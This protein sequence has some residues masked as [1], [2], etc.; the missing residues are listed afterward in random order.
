M[1]II[2]KHTICL[3]TALAVMITSLSSIQAEAENNVPVVEEERV[4]EGYIKVTDFYT[5]EKKEYDAILLDDEIIYMT[6]DMLASM[7]GYRLEG[8]A[9]G[10]IRLQLPGR[11]SDFA[12]FIGESGVVKVNGESASVDMVDYQK[13]FYY[14]AN[15]ML[16]LLGGQFFQ[17]PEPPQPEDDYEN[18]YLLYMSERYNTLDF[19]GQVKDRM[20]SFQVSQSELLK[21]GRGTYGQATASTLAVVFGNMDLRILVPYF[22]EKWIVTDQYEEALQTLTVD[23]SGF[24]TSE[25]LAAISGMVQDSFFPE[26]MFHLH[27]ME[28]ILDLPD[29][30]S[31]TVKGGQDL[32]AI[33]RDQKLGLKL[34]GMAKD[35]SAFLKDEDL[36]AWSGIL[37][38][39]NTAVD[40]VSVFV[41]AYKT[42][43][44]GTSWSEDNIEQL[45]VLQNVN[46]PENGDISNYIKRAADKLIFEINWPT[47]AA[48]LQEAEG[49]VG[50]VAGNAV[51][52]LTPL[53]PI[54]G[55]I[56]GGMAIAKQSP[57]L[58]K[59]IESDDLR[60]MINC[61]IKIEAIALS[62]MGKAYNQCM[63]RYK[64]GTLTN[65]DLQDL[66]NKTKLAL[67]TNLRNSSFVYYLHCQDNGS[68][69]DSTEEATQ[70]KRQI[71]QD[72]ALLTELEY[73]SDFDDVVHCSGWAGRINSIGTQPG[74]IRDPFDKRIWYPHEGSRGNGTP[75]VEYHGKV[76]FWGFSAETFESSGTFGNYY[77]KGG[78][79]VPLIAV[80]PNDPNAVPEVVL[81]ADGIGNIG[82]WNDRLYYESK[83]AENKDCIKSI[84]MDGTDP[85]EYSGLYGM[86]GA[87][88]ENGVLICSNNYS[89]GVCLMNMTTEEIKS[90]GSDGDFILQEGG[91]AY[92]YFNPSKSTMEIYATTTDGKE[93]YYLGSVTQT[94]LTE[95][96]ISTMGGTSIES[97][98]LEDGYLYIC[99]G[100]RAGTGM[101]FQ[102]GE[103]ARFNISDPANC[104]GAEHIY[105]AGRD[106]SEN[107]IYVMS[108]DGVHTVYFAHYNSDYKLEAVSITVPGGEPTPV[109]SFENVHAKGEIY[110]ANWTDVRTRP[111]AT[112]TEITLITLADLTSLIT[113]EKIETELADGS[114]VQ[115]KRTAIRGDW[116]YFAVEKGNHSDSLGWR[117]EYAREWSVIMRKNLQTGVI[118]Q[119]H[120]Y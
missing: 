90:L 39:V 108:A 112:G 56:S 89:S 76:Y 36:Q 11:T 87:D 23:D 26:A 95:S 32:M 55:V 43:E 64:N 88:D 75:Y 7:T 110:T 3:F 94:L 53:G 81:T 40:V 97:A 6:A 37:G 49:L 2:W 96:E 24:T 111:D 77:P 98:Q 106:K 71:E 66:K 99:Y 59:G 107:N 8:D 27:A 44:K 16:N 79:S 104:P 25:S 69:W 4:Q 22:N 119:L 65:L 46:S 74:D 45:K 93:T 14:H 9:H 29:N 33:I 60:Y 19:V 51:K 67:R 101:I 115:I 85:K 63:Q 35:K 113:A 28:D 17:Y 86:V 84:R 42:W 68:D 34:L 57:E 47:S 70:L 31:Q 38:K 20:H 10:P 92:Y 120:T 58:K 12:I 80:D 114:I 52:V 18:G 15:Q 21:E 102:G 5:G 109:A 72:Y 61:L 30:V 73:A 83:N 54:I 50:I 103:I 118:Q 91:L 62:E 41:A 117:D 100:S 78:V 13:T 116:F 1:K 48:L 105:G 82:I